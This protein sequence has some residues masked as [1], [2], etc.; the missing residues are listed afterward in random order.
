[1]MVGIKLQSVT[2]HISGMYNAGKPDRYNLC[3]AERV[4]KSACWLGNDSDRN[5][6]LNKQSLELVIRMHSKDR[7]CG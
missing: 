4:A 6:E 5:D 1:M 2:E 3:T 7:C